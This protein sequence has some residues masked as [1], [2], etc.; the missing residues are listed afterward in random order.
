MLD[1]LV[2]LDDA[3]M[4]A[5]RCRRCGTWHVAHVRRDPRVR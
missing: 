4:R 3:A 2:A 5:Y 1:R